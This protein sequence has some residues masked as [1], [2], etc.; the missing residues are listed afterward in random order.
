MGKFNPP[1]DL[2]S[3]FASPSIGSFGI[4]FERNLNIEIAHSTAEFISCPSPAAKHP[5]LSIN[6]YFDKYYFGA[7]EIVTRSSLDGFLRSLFEFEVGSLLDP[8]MSQHQWLIGKVRSKVATQPGA[9]FG[10]LDTFIEEAGQRVPDDPSGFGGL[11]VLIIGK[12]NEA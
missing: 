2:L 3:C 10:V 1:S 4:F 9:D 5:T 12:L 6:G 7:Q 11:S 8:S